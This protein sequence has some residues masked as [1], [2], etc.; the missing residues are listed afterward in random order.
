[1]TTV[2]LLAALTPLVS[3]VLSA[4]PAAATS[5]RRA[6]SV[7]APRRLHVEGRSATALRVAWKGSRTAPLFRVVYSRRADFGQA[8][9]KWTRANQLRITGLVPGTRYHVRVRVVDGRRSLSRFSRTIRP[10][11]RAVLSDD[12]LVPDE[13]VVEDPGTGGPEDPGIGGPE[14][15]GIGGPEE[16]GTGGPEEP[17]TPTPEPSGTLFGANY[18]TNALVDEGLYGGRARVARVF[19]QRLGGVRFSNNSAVKEAL[20][21]GVD[22]F[23]VSWKETDLAAIRTFLAGIP[24][25]L[26]VYTTFNHEPE[27]DHGSPGS[28]VYRAWSE[29]YRR[30]W[31]LQSPLMR[32]EG[33]VPTSILMAWTLQRAS[34]RDLADWTPAPGTVDVFAFDAYYGQG[35]D[36]SALAA[37]MAEA[38]RDAGVVRTGLAET[39]A[40]TSDAARLANTVEMR[41]ALLAQGTF[42]WGIYWNSADGGYD[43]RMDQATADAWF[44]D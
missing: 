17:G 12:V 24:D 28:E 14:E 15:P 20:A 41:R 34:G 42:E 32:A 9:V 44:E 27:N 13:P 21:D 31:S 33:F 38:A 4:S 35:K 19:F 1:M 3:P 26:T 6:F 25:G 8:R 37:R 29:E 16:P 30:Q 43:S 10:S 11:T 40:P 39:G 23:V 22:T 18:T 7:D 36:P 5:E 2:A